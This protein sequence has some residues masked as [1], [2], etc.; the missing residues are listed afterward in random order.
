MWSIMF[1]YINA[2]LLFEACGNWV[3][4]YNQAGNS[5]FK[6]LDQKF[7]NWFISF[8]LVFRRF[9]WGA[10]DRRSRA[11]ASENFRGWFSN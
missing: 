7:L 1:E 9:R 11:Q 4:V 6:S 8:S 2:Y 3:S 10:L 5:S